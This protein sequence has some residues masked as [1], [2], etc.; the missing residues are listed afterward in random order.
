MAKS[1]AR[2]AATAI[3]VAI[4]SAIFG[5][6]STNAAPGN[7]QGGAESAGISTKATGEAGLTYPELEAQIGAYMQYHAEE[8][9]LACLRE[10]KSDPEIRG[11]HMVGPRLKQLK[12]KQRRYAD[13][14][15]GTS[16]LTPEDK[17]QVEIRIIELHLEQKEHIEFTRGL[18]EN[19]RATTN[20]AL[21]EYHDTGCITGL[22]KIVED[23]RNK[24]EATA[25]PETP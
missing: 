5:A 22:E 1:R 12:V 16:M 15:D 21:L 8:E 4:T 24:R 18:F 23:I 17:R 11:T 19:G 2:V 3:A 14:R 20:N 6:V 13:F 10:A 9:L 25:H 7:N